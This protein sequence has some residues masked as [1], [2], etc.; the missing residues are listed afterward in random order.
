[1]NRYGRRAIVSFLLYIVICA[2][3][4]ILVAD[5]TLRPQRRLLNDQ[6]ILQGKELAGRTQSKVE[7]AS[8][9]T[10]DQ[11]QLRAWLISPVFGNGNVVLLLHGLSDNRLGMIG[12]AEFLLIHHYSVLMPDARAHGQSGGPIATYGLLES[13]DIG[14]WVNWL[15][16]RVHPTCVFGFGE[17][18]GAAQVLQSLEHGQLFCA[19]AAES[20]FSGLREIGY[21]RVGQFFHTGPW[22]GRIF[23]RPVI[24]FSFLYSHWKYG[25][26]L[27]S[28]SPAVVVAQASVPVLLIHGQMDSNIPIRHSR[29]IKSLA[30][31]VVLWEVPGADHCGAITVAR[32][33]LFAK[34]I[35]WFVVQ[36][37]YVVNK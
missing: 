30:P 23:L 5:A 11:V 18:M 29:K 28:V 31:K 10:V 34:L 3:A 9:R 26:D 15:N 16:H 6:D 12:Y 21:D 7:E 24:E 37:H 13:E 27:Q 1:M 35:A 2:I 32:D 33:E 22:L 4:G 17:S 14:E 8:I 25:I 19:V 36:P 20:P